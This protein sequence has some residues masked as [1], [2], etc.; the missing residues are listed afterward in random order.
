AVEAGKST[1]VRVIETY[2]DPIGYAMDGNELVWKRTLGRP[3]NFVT[4]PAGW[5][6]TSVNT[7]AT[8]TLDDEGRVK[9]RFINT[10]NGDL[11]IEIKARRRPSET[12]AAVKN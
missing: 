9:L 1:R 2:T 5:M 3:L 10:R 8:I 6:L 11:A 12:A 4:L 7:P